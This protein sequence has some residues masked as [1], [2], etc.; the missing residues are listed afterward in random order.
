MANKAIDQG[1]VLFREY[2]DVPTDFDK[3][4]HAC[5]LATVQRGYVYAQDLEEEK[6]DSIW[7]TCGDY[8]KQVE[9]DYVQGSVTEEEHIQ[10]IRTLCERVTKE[11]ADDLH[12]GDVAKSI[13]G[14][15]FRFGSAQKFFNLALKFLWVHEI[16]KEPPHLPVDGIVAGCVGSGYR[17]TRSN[18]VKEY[19]AAIDCCK[20]VGDAF[21]LSLAKLE[22]LLWNVAVVAPYVGGDVAAKK[23][24]GKSGYDTR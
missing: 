16:I 18:D 3:I 7:K 24:A 5:R 4:V 15:I 17:W 13:P 10:N 1:V 8:L 14:R 23:A 2:V 21:G 11:H 22:L 20:R 12:Q 19:L 6:R 9:S